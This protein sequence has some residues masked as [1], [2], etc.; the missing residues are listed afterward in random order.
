MFKADIEDTF[1]YGF[2]RIVYNNHFDKHFCDFTIQQ[3]LISLGY[4]SFDELSDDERSFIYKNGLFPEWYA[5]S[6]ESISG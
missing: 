1:K 4:S 5:I 2:A 6:E 3:F